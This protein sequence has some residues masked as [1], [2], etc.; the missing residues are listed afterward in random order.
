MWLS[1]LE[2]LLES[3]LRGSL[4]TG[5]W[6]ES[7]PCAGRLAKS[8]CL[9]IDRSVGVLDMRRGDRLGVLFAGGRKDLACI[10]TGDRLF[11]RPMLI[12][13]FMRIVRGPGPAPWD[14]VSIRR[15]TMAAEMAYLMECPW[16]HCQSHFLCDPASPGVLALELVQVPPLALVLNLALV[17]YSV[18]YWELERRRCR[19]EA[20]C[21]IRQAGRDRGASLQFF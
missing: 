16:H 17:P 12:L 5:R 4:I 7:S 20:A 10:L 2:M 13:R 15:T 1:P 6:L 9:T 8:G 19:P 18:L 3:S 11:G 21:Q 14:L